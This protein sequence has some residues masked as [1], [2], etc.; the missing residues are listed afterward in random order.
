MQPGGFNMPR[1]INRIRNKGNREAA[2]YI[3]TTDFTEKYGPERAVQGLA[4]LKGPQQ[5]NR[6]IQKE[7]EVA[8]PGL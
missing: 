5:N 2:D 6:N 1:N 7:N 3:K 8:G 4:D